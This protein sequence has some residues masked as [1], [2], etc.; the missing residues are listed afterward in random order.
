MRK[1]HYKQMLDLLQVIEQAQ[2]QGLF[3]DCQ[4][5]AIAVGNF[6]EKLVGEG[7]Q[8]V[9]LLEDYCEKLY[10]VSC[11]QLKEKVLTKSLSRIRDCIRRELRPD[12]LEIAFL[13]YNASMSDT[14]LSIY[15]AARKDPDC[16]AYWIPIPYWERKRDGS[17]S[18]KHFDG[19]ECY[20]GIACVDWQKYDI[21]TRHPDII[22]T[23]APYDSCNYVTSVHP[24]FYCERLRELTELLVYVPYYVMTD[25]RDLEVQEHFCT[26]PGCCFAHKVIVQSEAMRKIY[27]NVMKEQCGDTFGNP[28]EKFVT[29]GSPKFDAVCNTEK[30]D[31][32]IPEAW[33]SILQSTDS[34]KTILYNTS[35]T[36]LLA[37]SEQYLRKLQEVLD[38]FHA[39]KDVVLWWRPHPLLEATISAM[40]PELREAYQKLVSDYRREGWGIYDDTEDLHR[41]I[42]FSDAY[43]G[44]NSSIVALYSATGKPVALQNVQR[45]KADEIP[46]RVMNLYRDGDNFWFTAANINGL[47]RMDKD[48]W[49]LEYM[50][51]IPGYTPWGCSMYYTMARSGDKL[52]MAPFAAREIMVYDIPTGTFHGIELE[53]VKE[54]LSPPYI[55]RWKLIDVIPYK[56][57]VF[58]VPGSYPAIIK[59]DTVTEELTYISDWVAEVEPY[60][61]ETQR[62]YWTMACVVGSKF[63]AACWQ[64]NL[65]LEF[66]MENCQARIHEVGVAGDSF[67]SICND[68]KYLWLAPAHEGDFLR[69]NPESH[70]TVAYGNF[71]DGYERR[72]NSFYKVS[73]AGGKKW[74]FPNYGDSTLYFDDTT[75]TFHR[76]EMFQSQYEQIPLTKREVQGC[77]YSTVCYDARVYDDVI[78]TCMCQSCTFIAGNTISGERREERIICAGENL[79]RFLRSG[80]L[81]TVENYDKLKQ[82]FFMEDKSHDL[83]GFLDYIT[84]VDDET[85]V[86]AVK[87]LKDKQLELFRQ[88]AAH[89]D[90]TAGKVVY[91]YLEKCVMDKL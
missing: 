22:V 89:A 86:E 44:D 27:I 30:T 11:G 65:V 45:S 23:F 84:M 17:A 56:N 78:Y 8:T 36:S 34:R 69:W 21:E 1:Y 10:L 7:T 51:S 88:N 63:F 50:G 57:Q 72:K 71:P 38:T 58:F 41:A 53:E 47:F 90:G 39:R 9:S 13:S 55:K 68:G 40:R 16:D 18:T 32:S 70:E 42:A 76:G 66:D 5:G 67:S 4:D 24:D 3:A 35:I 73:V 79:N 14:I 82:C 60:I 74:L 19:P 28:E 31:V 62:L 85:H 43:Y 25:P 64:A 61:A 15:H 37:D 83:T 46:L 81:K 6:V 52:Y 49:T 29:L 75:G 91:E 54:E 77:I 48:S 59:L 33:R 80:Y 2:A 87:T 12:R 26:V 20:P